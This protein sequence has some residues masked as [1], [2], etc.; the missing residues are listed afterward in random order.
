MKW[1]L[2]F[3]LCIYYGTRSCEALQAVGLGQRSSKNRYFKIIHLG[4]LGNYGTVWLNPLSCRLNSV[5]DGNNAYA[6]WAATA[7]AALAGE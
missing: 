7:V 4:N 6:M 2:L 5:L 1:R 3:Y